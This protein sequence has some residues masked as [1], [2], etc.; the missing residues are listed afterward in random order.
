MNLCFWRRPRRMTDSEKLDEILRLLT[1]SHT[2]EDHI[3][4]DLT[5][6]EARVKANTSVVESAKALINGMAQQLKA[7]QNDPAQ[8]QSLID[9]L[10][11]SDAALAAAVIA[12]TPATTPA[13]STP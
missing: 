2:K 3:M 13:T 4:A 8:I 6:L 11:G 5:Q 12:N 9:Q 7:A 10:E 1:T